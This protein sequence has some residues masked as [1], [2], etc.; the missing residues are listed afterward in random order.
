MMLLG[1]RSGKEQSRSQVKGFIE[2]P[3]HSV[4]YNMQV[5]GTQL[6]CTLDVSISRHTLLKL[7]TKFDAAVH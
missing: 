3:G 2:D 6:E 1:S 7:H 5:R 4:R